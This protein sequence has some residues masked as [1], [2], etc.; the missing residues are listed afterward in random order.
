M[1]VYLCVRVCV[2]VCV[3]VSVRIDRGSVGKS[4]LESNVNIISILLMAHYG[5]KYTVGLHDYELSAFFD[6][7]INYDFFILIN[8]ICI[9]MLILCEAMSMCQSKFS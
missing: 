6:I 9:I 3:C 7:V 5:E 8:I 1:C 4:I 2:C